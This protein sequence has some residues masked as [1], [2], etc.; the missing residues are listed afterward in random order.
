MVDEEDL[1]IV[2]VEHYKSLETE[3]KNISRER[4]YIKELIEL[5]EKHEKSNVDNNARLEELRFKFGA[6]D[7]TLCKFIT[8]LNDYEIDIN[9]LRGDNI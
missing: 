5:N 7:T 2:I 3:M 9:D 6:I 1:R 8:L 4:E